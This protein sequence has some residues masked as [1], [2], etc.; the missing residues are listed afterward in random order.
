MLPELST[1]GY[2]LIS[3]ESHVFRFTRRLF[4]SAF[5]VNGKA[6]FQD[7]Q[8]TEEKVHKHTSCC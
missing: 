8:R 5:C 1:K 4:R 7:M 3:V 6:C 2:L